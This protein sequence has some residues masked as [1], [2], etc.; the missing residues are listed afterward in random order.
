MEQRGAWSE[1][2]KANC[3]RLV[4]GQVDSKGKSKAKVE[5]ERLA[6]EAREKAEEERKANEAE[7]K[8]AILSGMNSSNA[9]VLSTI[10]DR[11]F[12]LF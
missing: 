7:E 3:K 10:S 12:F 8:A 1:E 5:A 4:K 9:E 6:Q 2:V 11:Y